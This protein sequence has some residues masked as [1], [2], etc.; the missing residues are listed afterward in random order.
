M[1][2]EQLI[3]YETADNIRTMAKAIQMVLP[4][5]QADHI[6][7]VLREYAELLARLPRLADGPL[8]LRGLLVY[9]V[10]RDGEII[11]RRIDVLYRLGF[12]YAGTLQSMV[13]YDRAYSTLEAAE[14]KAK[15]IIVSNKSI[16]RTTND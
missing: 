13:S 6:A 3:I 10:E 14:M 5:Y 2:E 4:K 12:G 1:S 11:Q 9:E 15:Q 7:P 8:A 16:E